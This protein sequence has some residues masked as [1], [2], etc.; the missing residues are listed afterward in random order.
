MNLCVPLRIFSDHS[1]WCSGHQ[2]LRTLSS[3]FLSFFLSF[4]HSFF[5]SFFLSFS[6][7]MS[8]SLSLSLSLSTNEESALVHG[9]CVSV[10]DTCIV[11]DVLPVF[12]FAASCWT[13]C[14]CFSL[15]HRAGRLACVS[16]CDITPDVLPVFQF[17]IPCWT[18]CLCFSLRHRAGRLA[19]VSVCDI[20]LDVALLIDNSG[21]IRNNTDSKTRNE[22][23]RL[24]KE[25]I[26]SLLD[27]L[28]VGEC[29]EVT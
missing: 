11:L 26:K 22:N 7:S 24:L 13:S 15:R 25:F 23:Y 21:S 17:A 29:S 9:P 6:F 12:Q 10:C 20:V 4:F 18:S 27:I 14:L 1:R 28:D 3:L 8:L 5:L 16:V 19:C 2:S